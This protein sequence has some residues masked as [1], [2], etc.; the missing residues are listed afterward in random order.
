[1]SR[2]VKKRRLNV[3]FPTLVKWGNVKIGQKYLL[4]F[5]LAAI[6]FAIAAVLV[7]GQLSRMASTIEKVE[8]DSL[9]VNDVAQMGALVQRKDVQIADF[10][11]TKDQAYIATFQ[12]Q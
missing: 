4:T 10:I 9:H 7:Y 1:M 6:L 8:Q 5:S 11:I 3:K 12:A 2:L